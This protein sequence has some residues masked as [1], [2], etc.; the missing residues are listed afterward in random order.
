MKK[1]WEIKEDGERIGISSNANHGG[2]KLPK[3]QYPGQVLLRE[4]ADLR[5]EAEVEQFFFYFDAF[6]ERRWVL[7][8]MEAFD[9]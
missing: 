5:G 7:E 9:M 6:R 8:L 1:R 2:S 4:K 3:L